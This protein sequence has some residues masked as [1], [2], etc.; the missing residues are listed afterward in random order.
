MSS[1]RLG[2]DFIAPLFFQCR[3]TIRLKEEARQL[4]IVC[5][6]MHQAKIRALASLTLKKALYLISDPDV[7]EDTIPHFM[8]LLTDHSLMC[9]IKRTSLLKHSE[10]VFENLW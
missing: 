10:K 8:R 7:F 1:S 6:V 3:W 9:K 5:L 2:C 4:E